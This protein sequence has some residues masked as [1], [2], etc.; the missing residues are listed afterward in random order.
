METAG[1]IEKVEENKVRIDKM[2]KSVAIVY[3][4]KTFGDRCYRVV[5]GNMV[6]ATKPFKT[7]WGAKLWVWMN[8]SEGKIATTAAVT[9]FI[10][11][12]KEK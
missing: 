5:V 10:I 9:E 2:S 12:N 1:R 4:E 7:K 3:D 11:K 6:V 8:A